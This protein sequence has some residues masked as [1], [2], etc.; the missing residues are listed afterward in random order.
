MSDK[1]FD[2]TWMVT[3]VGVEAPCADCSASIS[4]TTMQALRIILGLSIGSPNLITFHRRFACTSVTWRLCGKSSGLFMEP[5]CG[6]R[7]DF[8][9]HRQRAETLSFDG[10]NRIE[11]AAEIL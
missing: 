10:K 3:F 8:F 5:T 7:G 9:Y 6:C 1:L 2:G 4:P 11:L